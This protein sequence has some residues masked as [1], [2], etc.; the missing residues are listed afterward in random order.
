MGQGQD[1]LGK[2]QK[3]LQVSTNHQVTND[4]DHHEDNEAHGLASHLH[5][6]PHGL[7]PLPAQHS[8]DNE[9]GMKKVMHVPARE[10]TVLVDLANTL[11]VALSKE[12]HPH[13]SK[14][15]DNNG[16]HQC[17]VAQGTH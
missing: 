17:Q 8:K 15:E 5:A 4:H 1:A 6:V 2:E 16:Q 13:H 14:D 12:L 10:F 9:E 11:F 7:D 3:D